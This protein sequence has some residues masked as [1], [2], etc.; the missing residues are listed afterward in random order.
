MT[1]LT[2]LKQKVFSGKAALELDQ[3]EVLI[4]E[5]DD[6]VSNLLSMD[7]VKE[8]TLSD[9]VE[10][11]KGIVESRLVHDLAAGI[12]IDDVRNPHSECGTRS[13]AILK[14]NREVPESLVDGQLKL[15][16]ILS[17]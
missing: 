2:L 15:T 7:F 16:T 8:D 10:L 17:T 14:L 3:I 12:N 5:F 6:Q 11:L 13:I 9:W 1:D 4:A